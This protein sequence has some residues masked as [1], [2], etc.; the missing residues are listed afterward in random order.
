MDKLLLWY[1]QKINKITF[2]GHLFLFY[3]IRFNF[4]YY[5]ICLLFATYIFTIIKIPTRN[6]VRYFV[7]LHLILIYCHLI[8]YGSLFHFLASL[9]CWS[10]VYFF[11]SS[12]KGFFLLASYLFYYNDDVYLSELLTVLLYADI[13][14]YQIFY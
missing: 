11:P 5:I 1:G 13:L 2:F 12:F 4:L 6:Q 9:Y 14:A 8:Y 10:L 3:D 7:L